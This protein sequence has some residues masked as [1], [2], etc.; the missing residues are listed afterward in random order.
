MSMVFFNFKL[1]IDFLHNFCFKNL[2]FLPNKK[3]QIKIK[4]R[5]F[6]PF[7]KAKTTNALYFAGFFCIKSQLSSENYEINHNHNTI[8]VSAVICTNVVRT[9]HL[10]EV[11]DKIITQKS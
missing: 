8:A 3:E 5:Y 2:D 9:L 10:W 11:Y 7:Y 4:I 6:E 1:K